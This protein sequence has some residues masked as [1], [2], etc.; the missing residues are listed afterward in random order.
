MKFDYCIGNPP[1]QGDN[2]MQLYPDFYL[3]AQDIADNVEM[4]FPTGWQTPKKS[5]G[6]GK[7]NKEEIKA[8]K[9]IVKIDNR[10]N[11]FPGVPGAES[12][13]IILWKKG[14]DNGLDGK[15]LVY[16][17]GENPQELKL[18][19]EKDDIELDSLLINIRDTVINHNSFYS[20]KSITYTAFGYK[21]TD[22]LHQ[23]NPDLMSRISKGHEFDLQTNTFCTLSDVWLQNK[24]NDDYVCFYGLLN[25]R[26]VKRYIKRTYVKTI[27]NFDKY[28]V[29]IPK[30]AGPGN[31]GE[32]LSSFEIAEPYIGSTSTFMSIG[33]FGT[34]LECT[35]CA[36]Y[37][38]TRFSR[39]LLGTKKFTRD[40]PPA[41]WANIPLQDFTS[42]SDIDWNK[43]ISDIDKQL[44]QKYGLS[45]DEINFIETHVKEMN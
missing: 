37:L 6:L 45:D 7:L 9:Q 30:S 31:F 43:S 32:E 41:V 21:Y 16:T 17:D 18:L 27:D 24:V 44:Y 15:Q 39:T 13:N 3:S 42:N 34:L 10:T 23:E 28:K 11:A 14:Y 35:N 25:N 40:N 2:H 19:C 12:T 38:K 36:K 8:D 22:T 33:N 4:I 1:Y 26:R 29:L 5:Q 20:I